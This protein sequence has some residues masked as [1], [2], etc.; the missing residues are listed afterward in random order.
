MIR[1][2]CGAV[3]MLGLL[4]L[5]ARAEDKPPAND[6]DFVAT[7]A[8]GGFA[9]V[10]LGELAE[11]RAANPKVKEFGARMVK[12]HSDANNKLSEVARAQKIAVVAGFDQESRQMFMDLSKLQ[13]E[14]FDQHYMKMMVEDHEKDVSMV[15][16]YA[17][18]ATDPAIKKFC[19]DT[20]PTLREHLK[21]A[22]E[23][24]EMVNKK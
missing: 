14:A 20:L 13:G 24:N 6:R 23:V 7:M 4:G 19:E 8:K 16:D 21:M 2:L 11:K 22:K 1:L 10:K 15:E 5:A 9:E 18:K 17:K 12:D 3:A